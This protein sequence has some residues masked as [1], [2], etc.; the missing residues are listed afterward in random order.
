MKSYA[1]LSKTDTCFFLELNV[2]ISKVVFFSVIPEWK[3]METFDFPSLSHKMPN[4]I[5]GR[6]LESQNHMVFRAQNIFYSEPSK[7]GQLHFPWS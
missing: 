4:Q 7:L 1:D 3:L 2:L 6:G 5:T